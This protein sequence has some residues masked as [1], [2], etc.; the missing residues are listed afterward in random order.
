MSNFEE[1]SS[2]DLSNELRVYGVVLFDDNHEHSI[3]CCLTS[4]DQY[5]SNTYEEKKS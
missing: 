5:F 2:K 4:G 3:D 1:C